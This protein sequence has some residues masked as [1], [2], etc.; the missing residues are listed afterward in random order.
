M[1]EERNLHGAGNQTL[2]EFGVVDQVEDAEAKFEQDAVGESRLEFAVALEHVVDLR[3]RNAED[4]GESAFGEV[5]VL[6]PSYHK[7]K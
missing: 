4:A 7:S 6:N 1:A 5:S 3:L 2:A